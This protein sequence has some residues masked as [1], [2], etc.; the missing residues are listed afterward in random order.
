MALVSTIEF[1]TKSCVGTPP[2]PADMQYTSTTMNKGR[3]NITGTNKAEKRRRRSVH[4]KGTHTTQ[5]RKLSP[6]QVLKKYRTSSATVP[7][8]FQTAFK[9][10]PKQF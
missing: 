7:A 3:Q 10:V 6:E 1:Y 8:M 9:Q 5:Y 4:I 2:K